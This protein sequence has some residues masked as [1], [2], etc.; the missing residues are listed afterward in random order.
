M[1]SNRSCASFET[2]TPLEL[3]SFHLASMFCSI[4]LLTRWRL[5]S[6]RGGVGFSCGDWES[7]SRSETCSR[8][9]TCTLV[10]KDLSSSGVKRSREIASYHNEVLHFS[11]T[12]WGQT[13]VPKLLPFFTHVTWVG[14]YS[15]SL[16]L[17]RT[18][19]R[20]F[21][22]CAAHELH[23]INPRLIKSGEHCCF[24]VAPVS[25]EVGTVRNQD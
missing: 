10:P 18:H 21:L 5:I 8:L 3:T 1:E 12:L 16:R 4:L 19:S 6:G 9:I 20:F 13:L 22:L 25:L 14:E 17:M 23:G 15:L 7:S 24:H 11:C 2:P